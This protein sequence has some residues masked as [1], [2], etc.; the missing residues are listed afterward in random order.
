MLISLVGNVMLSLARTMFY[1]VAK[2]P[3]AALDESAAVLGVVG[4][5]LKLSNARRRRARGRR[6]AYSRLRGDLPAGRSIRR[7]AEFVATVLS[8]PAPED[9]AGSHHASDDPTDDDSLLVDSG[10]LQRL[11]T[12]PGVL[13][14]T[15]AD[16]DRG[17]GRALAWSTSGTLGGGALLPAWEGASG[18][19]SQFLRAYHPSGIGSASA[20]PPY[21]GLL[22]LLA[23]VLLGKAWLA[24]D[25]LLLGC[26]PLAGITAFLALRRVTNSV[27]GPHL[28]GGLLRAA[29]D[30]LRRHLGRPARQ[31]RRVRAD[32]GD[33]P[34]G[35]PH[36]HP[37]AETRSASRVGD[38][39]GPS[40]GRPLDAWVMVGRRG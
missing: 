14:H 38:W 32:P 9:L 27:A 11:L 2:R 40:A 28:G 39:I 16:R 36:V 3:T 21:V 31:R 35:R 7:A 6:A 19:W 18:L 37:A 26:V 17:G 34:A 29:A 8:R 13:L 15:R 22:A 1:L 24:I 33:R 30:R 5:P 4:H 25:V 23:T 12:R 20:G 10:V